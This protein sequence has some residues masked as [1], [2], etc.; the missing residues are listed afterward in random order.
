MSTSTQPDP[1]PELWVCGDESGTP[2]I[3]GGPQDRYYLI[4]TVSM[5]GASLRQRFDDL[6]NELRPLVTNPTKGLFHAK[7]DT[8]LTRD[9]VFALLG[10]HA[11]TIDATI[12]DKTA[13]PSDLLGRRV[14]RLYTLLWYHH[15][16]HTLPGLLRPA[17]KVHLVIAEMGDAS[18]K[19]AFRDAIAQATA[20]TYVPAFEQAFAASGYRLSGEGAF[21]R[22][23][24][25]Q[26]SYSDART[27]RL[28][29]VADYCAWAIRRTLTENDER[30]YGEIRHLIRSE[31]LLTI[32]KK[33]G[34]T[35][36]A[37][38][39]AGLVG[40]MGGTGLVHAYAALTTYRIGPADSFQALLSF[41]EAL[42]A[43]TD[44]TAR[45]VSYVEAITLS[46]ILYDEA[47]A[48]GFLSF[49]GLLVDRVITDAPKALRATTAL[50][51]AARYALAHQGNMVLARGLLSSALYNRGVV[52]GRSGQDDEALRA[53]DE[54]IAAS[55][56]DD[57]PVITAQI[58][59]ARVNKANILRRRGDTAAA[60]DLYCRA[61]ESAAG[62]SAD[63]FLFDEP[64]TNALH[65]LSHLEVTDVQR[66]EMV[67][68][69]VVA[70]PDFQ[71]WACAV[72]NL[73]W[74]LRRQ[75]RMDD[76]LA[77]YRR[78]LDSNDVYETPRAALSL[79][80]LCLARREYDEADALLIR[81]CAHPVTAPEAEFH[82]A[83]VFV[84]T[85]RFAEAEDA[86]RRAIAGGNEQVLGRAYTLLGRLLH[87]KGD[88][89]AAE[90]A[91]K[92]AIARGDPADAVAATS[93]LDGLRQDRETA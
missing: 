57:L 20:A 21:H 87:E 82:R 4:V 59:K 56:N 80:F 16:L 30:G 38:L 23:P 36:A 92:Q 22:V 17:S 11:L 93:L 44:E 64:V 12:V 35:T 51:Q 10:S 25:L 40:L 15:I 54:V 71:A 2:T 90:D 3:A 8:P 69:S 60:F 50:A 43:E 26:F 75:E 5:E 33:A 89:D 66:A 78:A 28:L 13:L 72:N 61:L 58:A 81:A 27:E 63:R 79:G 42:L 48:Q 29:Q 37:S 46:D 62:V 47:R 67:Y 77:L 6:A 49:V 45:A 53:Y 52:F 32:T 1:R 24:A 41:Q 31:R 68:R 84:A 85:D 34:D 65:A 86:V 73:A 14:H 19:R 74:L 55:R 76:A 91:Y 9:R 83:Q 88:N 39:P 7:D 70:T 18:H